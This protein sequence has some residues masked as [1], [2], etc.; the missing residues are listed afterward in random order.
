MNGGAISGNTSS[1]NGGGVYVGN[2]TFTM[3]GGTISGNSSSSYGGGVFVSSNGTFR[4]VTGTIYGQNATITSLKNTATSGAV[5]YRD[6]SGGGTG[7]TVQCGTFS[8]STWNSYGSLDTSD[9]TIRVVNGV[10]Q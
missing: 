1:Y 6:D 3:N 5:L 9:D 10:L 2:G 8:G 7:G 4:I